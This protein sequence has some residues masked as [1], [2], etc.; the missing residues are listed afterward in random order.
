MGSAARRTC[1]RYFT[2]RFHLGNNG[3]DALTLDIV[4]VFE[5]GTAFEHTT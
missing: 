3:V 1:D 5:I 2:Y 4:V